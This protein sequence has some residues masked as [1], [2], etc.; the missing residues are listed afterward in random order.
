MRWASNSAEAQTKRV[1]V[2]DEPG[3]LRKELSAPVDWSRPAGLRCIFL[4]FSG[5]RSIRRAASVGVC[6]ES[7]VGAC[8]AASCIIALELSSLVPSSSLEAPSHLPLERF[9]IKK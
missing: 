2:D 8:R 4:V 7:A 9:Q 1:R 3:L 6:R 5:M